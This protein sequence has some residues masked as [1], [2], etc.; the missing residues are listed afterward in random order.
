M[1]A[2]DFVRRAE[3]SMSAT[4]APPAPLVLFAYNRPVHTARCLDSL[5]AGALARY[6]SL[7]AYVDGPRNDA[8]RAAQEAVCK[9]IDERRGGF[10]EVVV[11]R[12][13]RNLG[14]AASVIDGV[15][16]ML[17]EHESVIVLEDDLYCAP[18]FL[19]YMNAALR[20][21]AGDDR[22]GSIHAYCY[23][24]MPPRPRYFFL[25]GGDCWGWAT[26]RDR[27]Q[28]FDA[29]G[30]RLLNTLLRSHQISEFTLGFSAPYLRMLCRQILGRN[31]SWA[32]R[33]HASL[34]LRGKLTLYPSTSFVQ[35][36]GLDGS[37]THCDP[38]DAF[39]ALL[40]TDLP[41][42]DDFPE[43][44]ASTAA[45]QSFVRFFSGSRGAFGRLGFRGACLLTDMIWLGRALLRH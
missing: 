23:P 34:F 11:H 4:Q 19:E 5:A 8:D 13:E 25:K 17:A 30:R 29:D 43:P 28:Y 31:N 24:G 40:A 21:Y 20:R 39:Q 9:A 10:A 14:L 35:N 2:R 18:G 33:W 45:E 6:S 44:I 38:T 12:R 36:T 37:G 27:W 1:T 26:W 16:S 15:T 41:V 7:H 3:A 42:D 32:V 22:V